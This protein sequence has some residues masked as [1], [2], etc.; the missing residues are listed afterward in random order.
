MKTLI[1]TMRCVNMLCYCTCPV[2]S[3]VYS[4]WG[5]VDQ[6]RVASGHGKSF[7]GHGKSHGMSWNLLYWILYEPCKMKFPYFSLTK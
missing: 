7:Y 4:V 5:Y 3:H 1:N 2:C 6:R